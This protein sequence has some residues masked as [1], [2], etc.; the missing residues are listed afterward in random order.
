[1]PFRQFKLV[2]IRIPYLRAESH[3]VGTLF[4]RANE[5]HAFLF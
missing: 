3:A 5:R 2:T 4:E 1:M